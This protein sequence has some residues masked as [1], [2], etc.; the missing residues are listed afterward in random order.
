MFADGRLADV[1]FLGSPGETLV[2]VDRHKDFQMMDV[3]DFLHY[4]GL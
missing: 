1:Q 3:H 2:L 4:A